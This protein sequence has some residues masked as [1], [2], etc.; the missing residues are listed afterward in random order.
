MFR[1]SKSFHQHVKTQLSWK[2]QEKMKQNKIYIQRD[3]NKAQRNTELSTVVSGFFV[4]LCLFS[5]LVFI[6]YLFVLLSWSGKWASKMKIINLL[7]H[8]LSDNWRNTP[9]L[10]ISGF[11]HP[12]VRSYYFYFFKYFQRLMQGID[13]VILHSANQIAWLA[14]THKK[15]TESR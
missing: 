1:P 10:I 8:W 14:H 7:S 6:F 15:Q 2:T 3:I 13:L 4:I 11:A 9:G 5:W 12:K